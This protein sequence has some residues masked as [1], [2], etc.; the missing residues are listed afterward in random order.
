MYRGLDRSDLGP[1]GMMLLGVRRSK[2]VNE[3][4]HHSPS[5]NLKGAT[6]NCT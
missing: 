1:V 2:G 5:P 4:N 6:Q 3:S